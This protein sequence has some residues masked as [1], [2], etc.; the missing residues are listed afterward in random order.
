MQSLQFFW[1]ILSIISVMLYVSNNQSAYLYWYTFNI[2]M[3]TIYTIGLS[4][5]LTFL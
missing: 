1:G 4:F 2:I 3:L 5:N